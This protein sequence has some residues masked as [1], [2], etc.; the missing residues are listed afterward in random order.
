MSDKPPRE[1]LLS[2]LY[3]QYLD[4]QDSTD[5]IRKVSRSY[6]PG[7]LERLA[8]HALRE[9][10]RGALLALGFLGDY[11]V[12]HTLGRALHD[13]DRNVRTIAEN[14]IRGVWTRAGCD[15]ERQLLAHVI[16]LITTEHY[17]EAITRAGEL[18]E[19]AG[20][21]AE[22]WSQRA[23]A[24]FRLGRY[25]EAIRDCHQALE[26]NPYHFVAATTMGQAYLQLGNHVSALECFRRALRLNPN[27]EGVRAQISRLARIVEDRGF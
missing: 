15:A 14:G 24:Q 1:P 16:R 10:R 22:A 5:F 19:R 23:T 9:V 6:T 7:T 2:T 26:V 20:W 13:E 18:I 8:D 25:V 3:R 4:S 17:Q 27:L 21:F 11:S 12:N